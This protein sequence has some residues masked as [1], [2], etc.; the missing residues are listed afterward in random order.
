MVKSPVPP[1][2]K[3][4]PNLVTIF[5]QAIAPSTDW[6]WWALAL[7]AAVAAVLATAVSMNQSLQWML[8]A[9][10][11]DMV[12]GLACGIFKRGG[13]SARAMGHGAT[14]KGL[15]VAVVAGLSMVPWL[16][17]EMA[18]QELSIGS[19]AALWFALCWSFAVAIS[20]VEIFE[21]AAW[22]VLIP[23]ISA[24]PPLLLF[25]LELLFS[26]VHR[27]ARRQPG[28]EPPPTPP[29]L[30]PLGAWTRCGGSGALP[31]LT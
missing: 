29:G 24:V 6:P 30:R 18:G 28:F 19:G 22:L 26:E 10:I 23:L 12:T 2:L 17:V 7:K 9:M 27:L 5:A 3:E 14:V 15:Q 20:G 1:E 8:L 21:K 11:F 25:R 31:A 13:I 16:N 4:M